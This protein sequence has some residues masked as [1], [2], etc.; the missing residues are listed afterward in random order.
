MTTEIEKIM[1]KTAK[2]ELNF[3]VWIGGIVGFLV[4]CVQAL[5]ILI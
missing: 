4:G 1:I 3:I 2:K 5:I